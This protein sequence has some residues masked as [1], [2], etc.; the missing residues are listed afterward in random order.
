MVNVMGRPKQESNTSW[1]NR[2]ACF[3]EGD[4]ADPLPSVFLRPR[5]AAT[6]SKPRSINC[7]GGLSPFV[8]ILFLLAIAPLQATL[9]KSRTLA[10][11]ERAI[12]HVLV[13]AKRGAAELLSVS[14]AEA[15]VTS[16]DRQWSEAVDTFKLLLAEQTASAMKKAGNGRLLKRLDPWVTKIEK[17]AAVAG[18][19]AT[20]TLNC[21]KTSIR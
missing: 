21:W 3:F 20:R 12:E 18:S 17:P 2:P 16:Q 19:C 11:E 6:A 7:R 10:N 1:L 4:G 15:A 13:V 14:P 5:A 9:L 8:I